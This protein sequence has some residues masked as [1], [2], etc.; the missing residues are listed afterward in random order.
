[1]SFMHSISIK[2]VISLGLSLDVYLTQPGE[3]I[4]DR[5]G[6]PAVNQADVSLILSL[7][8]QGQQGNWLLTL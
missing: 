1:M 2:S 3:L 6:K 7:G 4:G 5:R 8:E